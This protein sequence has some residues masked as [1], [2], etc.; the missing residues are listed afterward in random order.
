MSITHLLAF[1]LEAHPLRPPGN[2]RSGFCGLVVRSS[3]CTRRLWSLCRLLLLPFSE[4]G[5]ELARRWVVGGVRNLRRALRHQSAGAVRLPA[6]TEAFP[7]PCHERTF[8]R[9]S[10]PGRRINA[11]VLQHPDGQDEGAPARLG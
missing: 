8:P 2:G 3:A 11:A 4:D 6:N 9:S 1:P 10:P 7:R 5:V